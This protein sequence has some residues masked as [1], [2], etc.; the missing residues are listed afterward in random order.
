MDR[1]HI[2][3][4]VIS[5]MRYD[6]VQGGNQR[7]AELVKEYP[8]RLIGCAVLN[9]ALSTILED[10]RHACSLKEIRMIEFDSY[11]H[12]YAPDDCPVLDEVFAM[13][14]ERGLIVK[15]FSGISAK[16]LPHQWE[17]YT[18]RYPQIPFIYL[19]MGCFDY[20]YSCV[21][22][23]KRN[24]NAYVET[25]NQYEMQILKKA[26]RQ[27]REEQ[28]VFGTTYP[29]RFTKNAVEVFDLFDLKEDQLQ[30]FTEENAKRLLQM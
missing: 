11:R 5:D 20:G 8:E 13:L 4:R 18:R 3:R 2:D 22:I 1:F 25:S 9:P 19:H 30:M 14:Q 26:F 10:T 24:K 17:R 28:I 16:A 23:V 15:V 12:G 29:Q 27:L 6:D 7:I 21:D